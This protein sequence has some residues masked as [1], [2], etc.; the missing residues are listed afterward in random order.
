MNELTVL[1]G[2]DVQAV[3]RD[4]EASVLD[5]VQDGYLAL[6]ANEAILPPSPL[7][8]FNE[9]RPERIIALPAYLGGRTPIAGIKWIAS[10]P[11]NVNKGLDRAS[12]VIVANDLETG[13]ARYLVEGS[14]ISA[15]RTAAS[16]ALAAQLLHPRGRTTVGIVGAGPIAY[17]TTR[18]LSA[19]GLSAEH[20]LVYDTAPNRARLFA[21]RA[22]AEGLAEHVQII[23]SGEDVL[24]RAPLVVLATSATT[25][26]LDPRLSGASTVLHLSLRDLSPRSLAEAYNVV[27]SVE[28]V[29]SAGTSVHLLAQLTGERTHIHATLAELLLKQKRHSPALPRIFSP[30][31]M[32]VLDL[33]VASY[34]IKECERRQ[35]GT[36]IPSFVPP[37]WDRS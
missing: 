12:A 18:Y 29:L 11:E 2:L 10:F 28:H 33:A 34:V 30:F 23:E 31:G 22:R 4:A 19:V 13:R 7:L 8:R 1:T 3:L 25:P 35:L 24:D 37:S 17:E 36:L 14:L 26:H 6:H 5:A 27:D 20:L 9:G 16:A 21:D 32:G 15:A